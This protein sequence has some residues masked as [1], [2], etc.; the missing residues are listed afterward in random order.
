MSFC[1]D[2][3]EQHQWQPLEP[4]NETSDASN[5]RPESCPHSTLY[6]QSAV[7]LVEYSQ[8]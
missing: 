6:V 5:D 2:A 4:L 1:C 3:S 8:V 7:N